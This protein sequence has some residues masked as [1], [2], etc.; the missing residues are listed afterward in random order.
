MQYNKLGRLGLDVFPICIGCMGFGDPSRAYPNWSLDE[1]AGCALIRH[2]VEAG[3][4][5][6]DTATMYSNG[7]SEEIVG[8]ALKPSP[9]GTVSSSRPRSP[10]P[11]MMDP[12]PSVCPARQS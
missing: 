4:N 7:G 9:T 10:L 1:E 5:F 2:A 8:R 11:P 6:F 12:M 3:V